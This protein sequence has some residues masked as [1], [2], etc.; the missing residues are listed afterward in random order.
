MV[1]KTMTVPGIG[2]L[3][4]AENTEGVCFGMMQFDRKAKD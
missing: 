2:Y 4:Y 3:I 1:S